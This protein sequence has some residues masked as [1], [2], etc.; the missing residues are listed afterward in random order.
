[1]R[2]LSIEVEK[3]LE[4]KG[5]NLIGWL[6]TSSLIFLREVGNELISRLCNWQERI[7]R[8]VRVE[9]RLLISNP[10]HSKDRVVRREG[11]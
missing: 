6:S 3:I 1:L 2:D 9:G 4:S 11:I 10:T 7:I 5:V 8:E